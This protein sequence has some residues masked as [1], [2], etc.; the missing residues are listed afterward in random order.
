MSAFMQHLK[1]P[2]ARQANGE[3]EVK[4]HFFEQRFYLGA[5]LCEEALLAAMAYVDLNPVRARIAKDIEQCDHTS[6]AKRLEGNTAE[7]WNRCSSHWLPDCLSIRWI[8]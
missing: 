7:H 8:F 1:Q 5:L 3:D 6:I 2:I 4:G